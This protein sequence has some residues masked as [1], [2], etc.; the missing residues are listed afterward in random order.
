[1]R[2][3][4][5]LGASLVRAGFGRVSG[6]PSSRVSG[7]PPRQTIRPIRP[8]H[9]TACATARTPPT[10]ARFAPDLRAAKPEKPCDGG[11]FRA[12]DSLLFVVEPG[13]LAREQAWAV[14]GWMQVGCGLGAG[15]PSSRV[16]GVPPRQTIRPIKPITPQLAQPP[17]R[18]IGRA[19]V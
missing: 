13:F 4:C 18:Q 17:A 14:A 9:A 2:T 12:L 3:G 8:R 16:S 15:W 10:N 19:H 6:W 1:M 11:V 5:G 7:V